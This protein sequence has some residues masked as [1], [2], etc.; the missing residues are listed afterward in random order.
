M[1][2][3]GDDDYGAFVERFELRPPPHSPPHQPL[4]GLT[5]AVKDIFDISGRVTG[6]GSPEWAKTHGPAT[7]TSPVVLAA[8]DAGAVCVGITVMD[9]MAYSIDGENVHHG[10]PRNPCAPDRVPG[11]SSSGSAVAVAA[12]LVDFSL[13]TD[14]GGSVRVPAACCGIFGFRPSH[15]IVSTTN[16]IPMAQSFDTVGWFARDPITLTRVGHVLFQL[17]I[18]A[19]KQPTRIVIPEDCFQC[20]SS[21][22]DQISHIL[23]KSM[24]KLFGSDIIN[25]E[26]LGD[27]I[28]HKVPSLGKFMSNTSENQ[29]SGIPSLAAISHSML[30]LQRSEFKAN[31]E[32]WVNTI[33]PNLGPGIS[34][35]VSGAL[36]ETSEN[37]EWCRAI[38]TELHAAMC[39]LLEDHGVLAIPTIPGPPPK[40]RLEPSALEPYHARAFSLLSIAGMSR[41]CQINI[42]LG[43]HDNL[44]VSVSLLARHGADHFLLNLAQALYPTLKEQASIAWELGD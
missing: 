27:Y 18:E 34:D 35:R 5:F 26:N 12:K 44:P 17:P 42:P 38:R 28:R 22:T 7:S 40:L 33:K 37:I 2:V 11:G 13:G 8:I 41:F 39:A 43:M 29:T 15:G 20:L 1:E 4:Q 21:P 25:H 31:H 9:E 24:E 30:R 32:E 16:V 36:S 23:N 3:K 10:T 19:T 6:F 14:T